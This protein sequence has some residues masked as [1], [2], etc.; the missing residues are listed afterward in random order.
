MFL[1]VMT[2]YLYPPMQQ[3]INSFKVGTTNIPIAIGLITMMYPPLAK[4]KYEELGQVFRNGL[5]PFAV[6][7]MAETGVDISDQQ[8]NT[9]NGLPVQEFD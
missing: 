8:S 1:V 3:I 9:I 7:V 5:N 2:G 4:V 6:Q